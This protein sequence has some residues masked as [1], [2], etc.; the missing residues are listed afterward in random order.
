MGPPTIQRKPETTLT[1]GPAPPSFNIPCLGSR[2]RFR[3][4]FLSLNPARGRNIYPFRLFSPFRS[5]SSGCRSLVPVDHL[6]F[7]RFPFL[8]SPFPFL[9]LAIPA[10]SCSIHHHVLLPSLSSF[11]LLVSFPF[12][13]LSL[14]FLPRPFP[15]SSSFVLVSFFV[16]HSEN[17]AHTV[18]IPRSPRSLAPPV[19]ERTMGPLP[20]TNPS[21]FLSPC[22][23]G[24]SG[25]RRS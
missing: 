25:L 6:F 8:P 10:S 15:S 4:K 18:L 16:S 3:S 20:Y 17:L 7:F 22:L 23:V 12:P 9:L 1:D 14:F 11:S 5:F 19:R 21:H 2:S 13:L 24:L